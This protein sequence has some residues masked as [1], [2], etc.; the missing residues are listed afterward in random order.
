MW[1]EPVWDSFRGNLFPIRD[2][3]QAILTNLLCA[4]R[5]QLK[6]LQ[7]LIWACP[8]QFWYVTQPVIPSH[9][10]TKFWTLTTAQCRSPCQLHFPLQHILPPFLSLPTPGFSAT[11]RHWTPAQC[12]AHCGTGSSES[13]SGSS[14]LSTFFFSFILSFFLVSSWVVRIPL[15]SSGLLYG[16][17][18]FQHLSCLSQK[19]SPPCYLLICHLFL[20]LISFLYR[21][22][23]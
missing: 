3:A 23:K 21:F 12:L 7:F 2:P 17:V 5:S 16:G 14:L 11:M 20:N 10:R 15:P 9:R 22:L 18:K 6:P 19:G 1:K 4:R 8:A 13:T